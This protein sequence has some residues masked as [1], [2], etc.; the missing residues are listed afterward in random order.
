[1]YLSIYLSI[2]IYILYIYYV[3]YTIYTITGTTITT[4]W[5]AGNR[6]LAFGV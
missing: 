2:Y 4:Q 1:M 5:G 3:L 6:F